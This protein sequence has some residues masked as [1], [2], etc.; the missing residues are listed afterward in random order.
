VAV[1]HATSLR[2]LVEVFF[3]IAG[4]EQ[5]PPLSID[6]MATDYSFNPTNLADRKEAA[7]EMLRLVE[8]PDKYVSGRPWLRPQP[9]LPAGLVGIAQRLR[10]EMA[11]V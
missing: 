1:V 11:A 10:A 5:W 8:W 4:R 7:D 3:T 6:A 9:G 2:R